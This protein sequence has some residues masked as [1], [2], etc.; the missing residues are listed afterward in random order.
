MTTAPVTTSAAMAE[1][2]AAS[3]AAGPPAR[4]LTRRTA[5]AAVTTLSRWWMFTQRPMSIRVA[6]ALTGTVE[7][8]AARILLYALLMILPTVFNAPLLACTGRMGRGTPAVG[9]APDDAIG[10]KMSTWRKTIRRSWPISTRPMSRRTAWRISDRV[11][12]R[13]GD[14]PFYASL[15]LLSNL[16]DR[17]LLYAASYLAPTFLVGPLLWC[18]VRPTRRWGLYLITVVLLIVGG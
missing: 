2:P 12:D 18:V 5:A 13:P 14:S 17:P 4:G 3:A 1:G 6:W 10:R 8:R 9:Q 7:N 11:G 15:W 16:I